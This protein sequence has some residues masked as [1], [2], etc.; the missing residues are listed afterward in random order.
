MFG[1]GSD[2]CGGGDKALTAAR[3]VGRVWV[4]YGEKGGKKFGQRLPPSP[5]TDGQGLPPVNIDTV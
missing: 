1:C 2:S 5:H 4:A 3:R